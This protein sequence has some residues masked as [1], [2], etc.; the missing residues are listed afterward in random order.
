MSK[1]QANKVRRY[2]DQRP[3]WKWHGVWQDIGFI[4]TMERGGKHHW[5]GPGC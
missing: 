5:N 4:E 3:I 2:L 1:A